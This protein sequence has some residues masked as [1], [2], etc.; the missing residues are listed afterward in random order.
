MS[1]QLKMG[2]GILRVESEQDIHAE[3]PRLPFVAQRPAMAEK[4]PELPIREA[5]AEDLA[6]IN[7]YVPAG[8]DPL[9]EA[10]VFVVSVVAAD[11]LVNR[12]GWRW[13]SA[14]LD[15]MAQSYPGA[16]ATIDHEWDHVEKAKGRV[17]AARTLTAEQMPD[18]SRLRKN[19][20]YGDNMGILAREGYACCVVDMYMPKLPKLVEKFRLAIWKEVSVGG[21][22]YQE[23]HCP[24][25]QKSFEDDGCTHIPNVWWM[26]WDLDESEQEMVVPYYERVGDY[27]LVEISFVAVP[28][29]PGAGIPG[30]G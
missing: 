13:R 24:V 22:T 28:N 3:R 19:P 16:I 10:D 21:L 2:H 27:D 4:L 20:N 9:T 1:R 12:S 14:E 17:F 5:N 11:N 26:T 15:Q 6:L 7:R 29:L 30:R 8:L 23:F 25:C 18:P